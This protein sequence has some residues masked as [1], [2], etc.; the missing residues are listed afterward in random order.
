[1]PM[2]ENMSLILSKW[3]RC[4]RRG[5]A[6]QFEQFQFYLMVPNCSLKWFYQFTLTAA[7]EEI[8]CSIALPIN[9]TVRFFYMLVIPTEVKQYLSVL[10]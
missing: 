1:M 3:L 6:V 5:I 2:P 7:M 4:L 10:N 8:H 9:G